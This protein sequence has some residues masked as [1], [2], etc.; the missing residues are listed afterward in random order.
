MAF[1]DAILE[2]C[3]S[4][5]ADSSNDLGILWRMLKMMKGGFFRYLLAIITMSVVLS[6]FDMITALLL[7]NI[8]SRVENKEQGNLFEGLFQEGAAQICRRLFMPNVCGFPTPTMS[9]TRA[10]ILCPR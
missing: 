7:K 8:I 5:D 4:E 6:G 2:Q 9:R 3:G 1:S 10:V